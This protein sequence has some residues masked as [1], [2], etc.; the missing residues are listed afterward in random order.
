MKNVLGVAISLMA[1]AMIVGCGGTD[2]PAKT[3]QPAEPA[4][5]A[6]TMSLPAMKVASIAKMGP[7]S[8]VGTCVG[9][10]MGMVEAEKLTVKGALYGM[11]FDNPANVKPESTR[12]EVRVPVTPETKNKADKK[13]GLVIKDVPEMTVAV[14]EYMGPYDQV[15]PTYEKLYQWVAEN[16]LEAATPPAMVEWYLSDPAKVKPESLMARVAV[17][18]KPPAPPPDTTKPAEEPKKEE[19]KTEPEAPTGK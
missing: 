7:Y 3:E 8:D 4:F 10:L 12:Y 14:T 6:Q 11:Y 18:V 16:K 9:D 2:Q 13:T 17:V 5:V 15:G 1:I 19:P